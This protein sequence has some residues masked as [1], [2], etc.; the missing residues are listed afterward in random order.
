MPV[1]NPPYPGEL[2]R[3]DCLEPLG[4]AVTERAKV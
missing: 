4:L 2:V 1:R 3:C